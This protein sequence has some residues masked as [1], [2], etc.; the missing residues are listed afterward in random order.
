VRADLVVIPRWF[1]SV[2]SW[3]VRPGGRWV[4]VG[5]LVVAGVGAVR[6]LRTA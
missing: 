4:G 5:G 6:V 2:G 1:S 3:G